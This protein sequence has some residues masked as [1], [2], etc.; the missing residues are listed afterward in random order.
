MSMKRI[1]F[2]TF[3]SLGDIYPLLALARELRLRGHRPAIATSPAYRELIE[4]KNIGFHPVRPEIDVTDPEILSRVMDRRTGGRYIVCD[5]LLPALR[6]AYE[7]T[8]TAAAKC[9]PARR[10]L[11]GAFRLPVR[12]EGG[13]PL[14]SWF[15]TATTSQTTP[16]GSPGWDCPH[17]S[18]R[19]VRR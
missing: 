15:L 18:S 7:D 4:S 2:C 11:D 12:P 13:G 1:V 14:D 10:S 5:I 16:R 6:E 8:A 3:G 17:R 9:R 19:T